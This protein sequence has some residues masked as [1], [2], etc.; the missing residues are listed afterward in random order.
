MCPNLKRGEIN[1]SVKPNA[2]SEQETVP[3]L[4]TP[5]AAIPTSPRLE[6]NSAQT[7]TTSQEHPVGRPVVK[8][9]REQ[10]TQEAN[11]EKDQREILQCEEQTTWTTVLGQKHN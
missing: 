8:A 7:E 10:N 5:M 1:N 4:W 2:L 3:K 6:A 11:V 9:L